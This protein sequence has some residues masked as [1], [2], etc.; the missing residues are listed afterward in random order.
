MPSAFDFVK[1]RER[2]GA[3]PF[4]VIYTLFRIILQIFFYG[5]ETNF[6]KNAKFSCNF[7]GIFFIFPK[8]FRINLVDLHKNYSFFLFY[9]QVKL[10]RGN[11]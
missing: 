3:I 2:T 9:A 11:C 10:M 8:P 5:E 4:F 7:L 6:L 1:K